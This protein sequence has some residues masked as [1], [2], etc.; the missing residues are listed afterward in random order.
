M[1]CAMII[2]ICLLPRWSR[3][4][5]FFYSSPWQRENV[6]CKILC[7]TNNKIEKKIQP[8]HD[9]NSFSNRIIMSRQK[10][11]T[12]MTH[13]QLSTWSI[14]HEKWITHQNI[15]RHYAMIGVEKGIWWVSKGIPQKKTFCR[16]I[17]NF[18]VLMVK[19]SKFWKFQ[20]FFEN[21]EFILKIFKKN[22]I[23]CVNFWIPLENLWQHFWKESFKI[24]FL[25]PHK[26]Q[27][28]IFLT[29]LF[30]PL[31]PLKLRLSLR[32]VFTQSFVSQ[33]T[34]LPT[35]KALFDG[36]VTRRSFVWRLVSSRIECEAWFPRNDFFER[37]AIRASRKCMSENAFSLSSA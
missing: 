14:W 26:L 35:Q 12:Q 7:T 31:K 25:I 17:E 6:K 24:I 28:F 9:F 21:F 37:S 4:F 36:N 20:N 22:K 2:I 34:C 15:C 16:I 1:H 10:R 5:L 18:V 8:S 3:I 33:F 30:L 11:L 32:T 27:F 19:L 13:Y 29:K 23:C